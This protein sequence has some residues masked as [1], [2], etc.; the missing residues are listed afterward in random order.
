M[1]DIFLTGNDI[2]F[3][4]NL[5]FQLKHSF[6]LKNLGRIHHFLGFNIWQTTSSIFL[7]QS[8]YIV[9]NLRH[10]RMISC[11]FVATLAALKPSNVTNAL[12]DIFT[13]PQYCMLVGSLQ[14]L[15]L[16]WP[17]ISYIVNKLCHHMHRPQSHHFQQL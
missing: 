6:Q 16:T 5:I 7:T 14:Y 9:E 10:A 8:H 1:D 2:P 17:N 12:F 15:T 3:I 4:Q 13:S 11:N